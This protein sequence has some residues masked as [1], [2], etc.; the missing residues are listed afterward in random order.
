MDKVTPSA[1]HPYCEAWAAKERQCHPMPRRALCSS[2]LTQ[3]KGTGYLG[4]VGG[5]G[6]WDLGAGDPTLVLVL[7]SSALAS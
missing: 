7:Q 6:A 5:C 2:V 3:A 1:G 4:G